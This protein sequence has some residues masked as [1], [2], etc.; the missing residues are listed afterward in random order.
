MR[1]FL[2]C[3]G[4]REFFRKQVPSSF[5]DIVQ[6]H[7]ANLQEYDRLK[8]PCSH[9]LLAGDSLG[10]LPSTLAGHVFKPNV[11]QTTYCEYVCPEGNSADEVLPADLSKL[12][13][14][15]PRNRRLLGRR[16]RKR[17]PSTGEIPIDVKSA[18]LNGILQEEVYV[19]Q[20]KGL[21]ILHI[22]SM[23]HQRNCGQ[24]L[25]T[26]EKENEMMMVQIYVDDIIFGGTSEKLVQN[27]REEY[28][29][30]VQDEHGGRI[31]VLSWTS[32]KSD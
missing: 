2:S 30:G 17:I 4:T 23:L 3:Q 13:L 16:K 7:I 11:W 28:D 27:F 22:L 29:K 20:P 18:F 8:I 10:L 24:D 12:E 6:G 26:L 9:A 1:M 21:K 31:E 5:T 32:S 14:M 15:P 19:A 25:F